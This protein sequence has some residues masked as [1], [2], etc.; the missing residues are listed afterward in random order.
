MRAEAGGLGLAHA[1]KS[2]L[3]LW[4]RGDAGWTC[5]VIKLKKVLSGMDHSNSFEVVAVADG[6]AV[7]FISTHGRNV[8]SFDL[9][10]GQVTRVCKGSSGNLYGYFPYMSFYTPELEA[11]CTSEGSRSDAA[12]V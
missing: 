7:I 5:R 11:A 4:S 8:F 2:G 10:S 9:K 12:S 1:V 3:C 6:V